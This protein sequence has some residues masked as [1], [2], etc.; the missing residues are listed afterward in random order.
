MRITIR[1]TRATMPGD[2]RATR[3]VCANIYNSKRD[4]FFNL[5]RVMAH[6][7][8]IYL[9]FNC[10]GVCTT[11]LISCDNGRVG[12]RGRVIVCVRF[13]VM[14][15][16]ICGRLPTTITLHH[17]CLIPLPTQGFGV[18]I[19]GGKNRLWLLILFIGKGG[20]RNIKPYTI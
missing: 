19:T 15:C 8:M 5:D 6:I 13:R 9:F 17:I 7:C 14:F 10:F 2:L 4:I 11:R 18:Y 16:Y 1:V 3:I 20:R 12:I